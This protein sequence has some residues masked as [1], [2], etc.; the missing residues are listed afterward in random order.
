M[1]RRVSSCRNEI[2]RADTV[3]RPPCSAAA[4][5]AVRVRDERVGQPALDRDRDHRELLQHILDG[6][7]QPPDPG[8]HGIGDRRRNPL[9]LRRGQQLVDEE[10]VARGQA[11]QVGGVDRAARAEPADG[12]RRQPAQR[13]PP[14]PVAPGGLAEQAVQRMLAV[15]LIVTVGENEHRRQLS[16]PPDQEAQRVQ[17]GIV[18]PVHVLDDQHRGMIRPVQLRAQRAEQ[19]VTVAA[20]RH[21]PAEFRPHHAHE[22]AE[23]A[24]RPRRGQIIAVAHEHP[25]L[26]G[27]LPTHRVRPGLTCRC[28]P[29]RRPGPRTRCPRPPPAP[30]RPAPRARRRAPRSPGSPLDCRLG[31]QGR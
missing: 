5:A 9:A 17:R 25:A 2:R 24:Q 30:R 19:P 15:Q 16:D 11:E 22:I 23:R 10:R 14:G 7:F 8:Q 31:G 20:V 27:K 12:P 4:S 3:S 29:H 1:A 13:Q 28:P 21:G 6:R 18:G 26:G